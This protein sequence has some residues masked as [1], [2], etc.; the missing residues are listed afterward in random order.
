MLDRAVFAVTEK[1]LSLCARAVWQV[2]AQ[3]QQ[4][5]LAHIIKDYAA[6]HSI[7]LTAKSSEFARSASKTIPYVNAILS[8]SVASSLS[9]KEYITVRRPV[10]LNQPVSN[11]G[12]YDLV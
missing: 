9:K 11:Y 7:Y 10:R 3:P 2:T 12:R 4:R 1:R 5:P 8:I 6:H